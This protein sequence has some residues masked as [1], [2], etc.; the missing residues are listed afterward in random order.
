MTFASDRLVDHLKHNAQQK[1]EIEEQKHAITKTRFYFE[2]ADIMYALRQR[3]IGQSKA[4]DE[5]EKMLRVV[6]A[7]FS[8]ANRPLSVTL[9]LGPTGVGKTE[10]VRIISQAIYGH[11]D[12]FCRI[13]M[14]T[15]A[16]EHYA[17]AL[18]GAP[19]GYVGSKEGNTLF[20][21]QAIQGSFSKPG[22]ILFDEIEKASNEVI[23]ALLNVLDTGY[24]RLTAGTKE[25][26]F[27]NCI[28]FMTSNIGAK[29]SQN[30]RNKMK[31]FPK[32]VKKIANKLKLDEIEVTQRELEKKFDP[33]FLNRIDRILYYQQIDDQYVANIVQVE[34]DKLNLRLAKQGRTIEITKA[35]I[36]HLSNNYELQYG[37][38][39]IARQIRI[40]IEPLL[41]KFFLEKP[42]VKY[43]KLDFFASDFYLSEIRDKSS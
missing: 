42:E 19:P 5:I 7:D 3:I 36:G 40:R 30:R 2:P 16:Q 35:V 11:A 14:N 34:I 21:L 26:D 10:T 43:L 18:T 24:L 33:E 25:I 8:D 17:A 31:H 6:K 20:N 28:I 38:R 22:I 15:L 9:M 32:I 23:R 12:A 41:A 29:K 27:R 37:A 13:D 4:L 39:G 1:Y